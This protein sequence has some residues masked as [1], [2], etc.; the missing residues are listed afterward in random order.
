MMTDSYNQAGPHK[1]RSKNKVWTSSPLNATV[2]MPSNKLEIRLTMNAPHPIV[3]QGHTLSTGDLAEIREIIDSCRNL[4]RTELA[5]TICELFAWTRPSGR[6]K[7]V[8]C[9]QFLE[10]IDAEGLIVLPPQRTVTDNSVRIVHGARTDATTIIS[11]ELSM[12]RPLALSMVT[13]KAQRQLWYEYVDRYHYLG[14]HRPF[15]AQIRYFVAPTAA[16]TTYLGCLQFSSPAWKMAPRDLWLAWDNAHRTNNLQ[17]IISNSRFLIFPWIQVKNLASCIL[18]LAL[19]QVADDWHR[20]YGIK[21][22][23]VETLVDRQRFTGTCYQAA[24]WIYL[25]TTT[26]RGR[27][28]RENRRRDLCPKDIYVYP[29]TTRFRR[30]L[31][32]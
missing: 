24:N 4:S 26:G 28:D 14:Y 29:L 3:F 19:R 23:L 15:G 20:I 16:P 32:T 10:R 9:R 6:L 1:I 25:G 17:Q 12:L 30:E 2:I 22:V 5:S 7:T 18:A 8:E 21:P 31:L 27:M 11:T 13:T